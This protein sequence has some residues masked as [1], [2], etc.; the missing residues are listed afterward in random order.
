MFFFPSPTPCGGSDLLLGETYTLLSH[1]ND[2]S[3]DYETLCFDI[4]EKSSGSTTSHSDHSLSEYESFYF[5]VD[6][7]REKSSGSTTSHSNHSLP[8]YESFCFDVNHIKEKKKWHNSLSSTDPP[9]IETFLS[10]PFGN[11]DK[12]FDS[13]ILRIDGV[14]SFTRKSP[15]LLND[16]FKIV[17]RHILSEISSKTESSVSFHPMDKEMWGE[18]PYDLEDLCA[19]FQSSN[20]AVSD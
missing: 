12:V 18:I 20:H 14:L 2:S 17:K 8:E 10:F 19:C 11:K 3:P 4:G 15:H 6:H 1:F 5:D 13:R 9:E 7:I 16:N